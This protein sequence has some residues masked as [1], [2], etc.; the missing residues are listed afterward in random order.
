MP[1]LGADDAEDD[2]QCDDVEGVRVDGVAGEVFVEDDGP[3]D[4]GEPEEQPEGAKMDGPKV[5]IGVHK[6]RFC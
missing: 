3:G 5:Q 6:P 4:G 2:D 1:D